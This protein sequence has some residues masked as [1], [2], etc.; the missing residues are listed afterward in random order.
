MKA[1]APPPQL[2]DSHHLAT[3][4]LF[5]A[6][7]PTLLVS[8]KKRQQLFLASVEPGQSSKSADYAEVTGVVQRQA[9]RELLELIESGYLERKGRGPSTVYVRTEKPS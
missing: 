5:P 9:R 3:L 7:E 1:N 2:D 8:L 6:P 4:T